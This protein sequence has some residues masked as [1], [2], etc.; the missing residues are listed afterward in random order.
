MICHFL[1]SYTHT[2]IT[3]YIPIYMRYR[4]PKERFHFSTLHGYQGYS[5]FC[6]VLTFAYTSGTTYILCIFTYTYSITMDI[7]DSLF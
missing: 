3:Y 4:F 6:L 5:S 1:F 2:Y 7:I